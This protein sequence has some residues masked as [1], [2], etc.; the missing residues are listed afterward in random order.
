MSKDNKGEDLK[1][2][3]TAWYAPELSFTFGPHESSG[4]P[5]LVLEYSNG[6]LVFGAKHIELSDNEI[7]ID[8]PSNGKLVSQEEFNQIG[9]KA[10][11]AIQN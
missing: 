6:K 9:K 2:D 8:K 3:L 5:G 7:T 10:V 4:L 1:F 11:E